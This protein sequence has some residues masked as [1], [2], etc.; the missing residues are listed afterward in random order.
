MIRVLGAAV[1]VAASVIAAVAEPTD[2][3]RELAAYDKRLA[4]LDAAGAPMVRREV[5]YR[6]A[7]LTGDTEAIAKL[8]A[9]LR[10]L[11]GTESV[12]ALR[13]DLTLHRLQGA[14]PRLEGLRATTTL[15]TLSLLRAQ[16]L[17][18]SGEL[19]AASAEFERAVAAS[20]HW[21]ARAGLAGLEA[22]RGRTKRAEALYVD[23]GEEL[24]V[25]QMRAYAWV[26]LQRGLIRLRRGET[27]AALEF[28]A[29]AEKA[30]GGW[31][32]VD[33]HVA[34]ALA[35]AG[36]FDEAIAR[37]RTAIDRSPRP[38]LR[39]ALGDLYLQLGRRDEA[40]DWLD[41]ARKSYEDSV[42]RG[43][44]YYMHHLARFYSDSQLDAAKAVAY[45]QRDLALRP[46]AGAYDALAWAFYR[47]GR[48]D[49][50]H[51]AIERALASGVCDAHMQWH[52]A[53]IAT[54][55]GKLDEGRRWLR[56]ALVMNAS[57]AAFHVHR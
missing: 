37:Y 6:R 15:S 9:S 16:I 27:T 5:E 34:E 44:T 20:G 29:Q 2:Y 39:H 1:L 3:G 36:R 49:E 40:R 53:L 55:R 47:A 19:E 45:A 38:E 43:E 18:Q 8:A 26:L 35:V 21:E 50:S 11:S 33:D 22:S 51:A 4:E 54:A 12:L 7:L 25:R 52:A 42:A 41:R 24:T 46:T 23:A 32:L 48:F 17:L 28:Y 30:Y 14:L 10:D 31:W 56:E 57:V 13:I